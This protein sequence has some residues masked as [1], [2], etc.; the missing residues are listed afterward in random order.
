MPLAHSWKTL[1]CF[2]LSLIS[3]E[4]E[5]SLVNGRGVAWN[6]NTGETAVLME[7]GDSV[8]VFNSFLHF[9]EII[10]LEQKTPGI[11]WEEGGWAP[12]IQPN[13]H[14]VLGPAGRSI[15]LDPQ[16]GHLSIAPSSWESSPWIT[17]GK[18]WVHVSYRSSW[19]PT[20]PLEWEILGGERRISKWESN[21]DDVLKRQ[22]I[23]RG[24]H[25]GSKI[26]IRLFHTG[27]YFPTGIK[28]DWVE[29][30]VPQVGPVGPFPTQEIKFTL[31]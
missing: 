14:S 17:Y 22:C 15:Q 6:P 18:G 16:R 12:D 30:E 21:V 8:A 13:P 11:R 9:Q 3:G 19:V 10:A 26:R 2:S 7:S 25:H 23:L 31:E 28:S 29:F 24:I 1:L 27:P 5:P 20:Q 4:L